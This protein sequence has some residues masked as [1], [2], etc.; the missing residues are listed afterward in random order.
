M[1][2]TNLFRFVCLL[3]LIACFGLNI[4]AAQTK[5]LLIWHYERD[6]AMDVAWQVAMDDFAKMH[7]DVKIKFEF[8]SK[9]RKQL[10]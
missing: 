1:K 8:L 9:F 4:T 10:E 5:E 6:N 7:P 2:K 3:L